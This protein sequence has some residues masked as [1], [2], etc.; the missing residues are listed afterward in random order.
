MDPSGQPGTPYGMQVRSKNE[1]RGPK[2]PSGEIR[3]SGTKRRV[4]P[5][6]GQEP[7]FFSESLNPGR[8]NNKRVGEVAGVEGRRCRVVKYPELNKCLPV[9]VVESRVSASDIVWSYGGIKKQKTEYSTL[10]QLEDLAVLM[11]FAK[12][13]GFASNIG[14]C[15]SE[16]F[17][18]DLHPVMEKFVAL[19]DSEN[20]ALNSFYEVRFYARNDVD[21]LYLHIKHTCAVTRLTPDIVCYQLNPFDYLDSD[22]ATHPIP[23]L[24]PNGIY[25]ELA[26]FE[27]DRAFSGLLDRVRTLDPFD[28]ESDMKFLIRFREKMPD[29][30]IV[31]KIA[32]YRLVTGRTDRNQLY[33]S[34]S[35]P[36]TTPKKVNLFIELQTPFLNCP[37]PNLDEIFDVDKEFKSTRDKLE[38]NPD[39]SINNRTNRDLLHQKSIPIVRNKKQTAPEKNAFVGEYLGSGIAQRVF[40]H[41]EFN[42]L[43][44]KEIMRRMNLSTSGTTIRTLGSTQIICSCVM[45]E[46][47][48][49]KNGEIQFVLSPIEYIAVPYRDHAI[50]NEPIHEFGCSG[51]K[52]SNGAVCGGESELGRK[53][54]NS[55]SESDAFNNVDIVP[56]PI[57]A[58]DDEPVM[59]DYRNRTEKMPT[60]G[61]QVESESYEE[62]RISVLGLQRKY[63]QGEMVEYILKDPNEKPEVK[64]EIIK[65]ILDLIDRCDRF[66]KIIGEK[67][68]GWV[69]KCVI[70]GNFSNFA[71]DRK[72]HQLIYLDVAPATIT[73]DGQILPGNQFMMD[74]F[75]ERHDFISKMSED[76]QMSKLFVMVMMTNDLR[77]LEKTQSRLA[78]ESVSHDSHKEETSSL[79]DV[80]SKV[81][82]LLAEDGRFLSWCAVHF[83]TGFEDLEKAIDCK[84]DD[85]L[86]IEFSE[87]VS[88]YFGNFIRNPWIDFD[89]C[90]T[91]QAKLCDLKIKSLPLS[92][93]MDLLR[94]LSDVVFG[95][96]RR[97]KDSLADVLSKEMNE[98]VSA[99]NEA[100]ESVLLDVESKVMIKMVT[101]GDVIHFLPN[102]CNTKET[103]SDAAFR[104]LKYWEDFYGYKPV[105]GNSIDSTLEL[106]YQLLADAKDVNSESP[107]ITIPCFQRVI[108]KTYDKK[109]NVLLIEPFH[110]HDKVFRTALYQWRPVSQDACFRME[111]CSGVEAFHEVVE[112]MTMDTMVLV[113][114]QP[115]NSYL[116]GDVSV[117]PW[118]SIFIKKKGEQTSKLQCSLPV[119]YMPCQDSYAKLFFENVLQGLK[120]LYEARKEISSGS[121]K[122][123]KLS[124]A[125]FLKKLV[126]WVPGSCA[127]TLENEPGNEC[128]SIKINLSSSIMTRLKPWLRGYV[129]MIQDEFG[130]ERSP[131]VYLIMLSPS[132]YT[133]MYARWMLRLTKD[134]NGNDISFMNFNSGLTMNTLQEKIKK[135]I[136]ET[137]SSKPDFMF[138]EG[139]YGYRSGSFL[140]HDTPVVR[141]CSGYDEDFFQ[142]IDGD[143]CVDPSL[144]SAVDGGSYT[145]C[146]DLDTDSMSSLECELEVNEKFYRDQ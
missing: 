13:L 107:L 15:N 16:P 95:H 27:G 104:W 8:N 118:S 112:N 2:F 99:H 85:P 113:N 45:T 142:K 68:N 22:Q 10:S 41:A 101:K 137:S 70:D 138:I 106:D 74:W 93:R 53:K 4:T 18:H 29:D 120:S 94:R 39:G 105:K 135:S 129:D 124:D 133:R 115:E 97:I 34:C 108:R 36:V 24:T 54:R 14:Q 81:S 62:C 42:K 30:Q 103:F 125:D 60:N 38:R 139:G 51:K 83:F 48:L 111:E 19:F 65:G 52:V 56:V 61:S 59:P 77:Q 80:V 141:V 1:L 26:G 5:F 96:M 11:G 73:I 131:R 117:N 136:K 75:P 134:R 140:L 114:H 67:G 89:K 78:A 79:R 130:R 126:V 116:I 88:D 143:G 100:D 55:P 58:E 121:E 84:K 6:S 86:S 12:S 91:P 7:M 92:K 71:Y 31:S 87:F 33:F 144:E 128:V 109:I 146:M 127:E 66:N 132:P 72:K 63:D 69:I 110:G 44:A 145:S 98:N 43:A 102:G 123:E 76:P 119:K 25:I 64:F 50:D 57:R 9:G 21:K 3:V 49:G 23:M 17:S 47:K 32:G 46:P 90:T 122:S 28:D 37:D 82:S 40:T 35:V 20:L